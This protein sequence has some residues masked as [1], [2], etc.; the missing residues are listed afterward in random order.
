MLRSSLRSVSSIRSEA[1]RALSTPSEPND[2]EAK[3]WLNPWKR[4]LP[5]KTSTLTGVEEVKIDWSYVERLMP[6]EVVPPLPKHSSYP[7]PSGW[8][9]PQDKRVCEILLS[10]PDPPP[11][12]PYYVRRKRDHTLPL[13]LSRKKDLL[14]EVTLD[15]DH[16]ELVVMKEIE[17]DIFACEK[18]LRE[19]LETELGMP[20]A[21]HVDELK[22]RITIKGAD[23]SLVEK[24][25]FSR[26]F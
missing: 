24:F 26:G 2:D 16:V 19:F 17:G 25:L 15:I 14:N 13:Y 5:E 20:V 18:D 11:N 9:P 4:A 12:L 8:Q 6:H 7:T 23:R 21:T 10:L 22:G 1:V 3:P